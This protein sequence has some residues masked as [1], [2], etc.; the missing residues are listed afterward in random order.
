MKFLLGLAIS[1]LLTGCTYSINMVHTK[2]SASD[3]IDEESTAAPDI[4]AD[5]QIPQL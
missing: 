5:L 1:L 3:V 2:G 4:K